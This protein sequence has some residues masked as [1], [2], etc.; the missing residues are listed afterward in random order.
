MIIGKHVY[1]LTFTFKFLEN[2]PLRH[3]HNSYLANQPSHIIAPS[4]TNNNNWDYD[5]DQY[6][7]ERIR[8][9]INPRTRFEW[10]WARN[11][12]PLNWGN[13]NSVVGCPAK[14]THRRNEYGS[15][16][17]DTTDC[18]RIL[19]HLLIF[20]RSVSHTRF[21]AHACLINHSVIRSRLLVSSSPSARRTNRYAFIVVS[22]TNFAISHARRKDKNRS[23]WGVCLNFVEQTANLFSINCNIVTTMMLLSTL[24]IEWTRPAVQQCGDR[25]NEWMSE[26]CLIKYIY[27]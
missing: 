10:E 13:P 27:R 11:E 15:V 24:Y 14:Y 4:N 1:C 25:L 26:S 8:N 12:L 7:A 18:H 19:L 20:R 16:L 17:S 3:Q 9:W 23:D 6:G 2:R 21:L 22:Q 5:N